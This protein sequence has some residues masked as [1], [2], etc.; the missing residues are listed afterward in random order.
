MNA[1]FCQEHAG[2]FGPQSSNGMGDDA[3]HLCK[4][5][6]GF[7][8]KLFDN[9]SL[10]AAQQATL[11]KL[12][13]T[14]EECCKP[15]WDGYSGLAVSF[16]TY[17]KAKQFI[18]SFPTA[19]SAPEL[20]VDPDGEISFEWYNAPRKVFSVSIGPNNELTYAGLFGASKTHGTETFHDEI[21]RFV[22]ENIRRAAH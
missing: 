7:R 4:L 19:L 8:S 21:P 16:E 17:L 1:T 6:T 10:G 22:L 3:K 13:S 20:S 11:D 9:Q 18:E 12:Y 14:F 5:V 2:I 15:N